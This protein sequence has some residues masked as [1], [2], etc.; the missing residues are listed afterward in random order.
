MDLLF[1]DKEQLEKLVAT[2]DT[3]GVNVSQRAIIVARIANAGRGRAHKKEAG[4]ITQ[5][6]TAKALGVSR[7]MVNWAKRLIDK[8]FEA[9]IL[10]LIDRIEKGTLTLTEACKLAGIR[11]TDASAT[12]V[13]KIGKK[14]ILKYDKYKKKGEG[15]IDYKNF[16]DPYFEHQIEEGQNI[17]FGAAQDMLKEVK[18]NSVDLILTDP[19]YNTDVDDWD[20]NFRPAYFLK[21]FN[22]IL[23]PGGSALIFCSDVILGEYLTC[24]I[25][26]FEKYQL[27]IWNKKNPSSRNQRK[28]GTVTMYK[29]NRSTEL[30]LWYVKGLTGV[31]SRDA[32]F[33]KN[34]VCFQP[35]LINLD[36]NTTKR[37]NVLSTAVIHH[38]EIIKDVD[39]E[40]LHE[41]QKPVKLITSLLRV[42]SKEG[43][44]VCDPFLGTGTTAIACRRLKRRLIGCDKSDKYYPEI[45]NR[46]LNEEGRDNQALIKILSK[47]V[48]DIKKSDPERYNRMIRVIEFFKKEIEEKINKENMI[49]QKLFWH[50]AAETPAE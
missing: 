7:T 20:K 6:E 45:V 3:Q 4:R 46:V 34:H 27:L 12:T 43:D 50:L 26:E 41:T 40:K 48:K 25:K 9:E 44:L 5:T 49:K 21:E 2:L 30:I 15:Y 17:I 11:D 23:R 36:V 47:S 33:V 10:E 37:T 29:Y 39:G 32:K 22:R 24:K 31:K 42:H 38:T 13:A 19:P 16:D 28:D 1:G 14:K 8:S 35:E 18:D